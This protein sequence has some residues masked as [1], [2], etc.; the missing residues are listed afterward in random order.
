[1]LSGYKKILEIIK[2]L[3]KN[4]SYIFIDG[5]SINNFSES[6]LNCQFADATIVL[7]ST[8]FVKKDSI[9]LCFNKL[10]KSGAKIEGILINK[11]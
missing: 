3:K 2:K 6:L 11:I 4:Y 1:M 5:S 8:N 10:A 9:D 7:I